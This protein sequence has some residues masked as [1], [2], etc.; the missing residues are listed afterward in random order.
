[1]GQS[2]FLSLDVFLRHSLVAV[3]FGVLL[4]ILLQVVGS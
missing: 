2:H 4:A 3:Q 1:M